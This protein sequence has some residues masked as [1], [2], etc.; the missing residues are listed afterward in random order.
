V[1]AVC[2]VVVGSGSARADE[3]APVI[4]PAA[5]AAPAPAAVDATAGTAAIVD[6]ASAPTPPTVISPGERARLEREK[7]RAATPHVG[8]QPHDRAGAGWL[9]AATSVGGLVAGAA[10]GLAVFVP[11][12]SQPAI[13][14]PLVALSVLAF[15]AGGAALGVQIVDDGHNLALISGV[16][17]GGALLGTALGVVGGGFAGAALGRTAGGEFSDLVGA[18][19]GLVIGGVVGGVTGAALGGGLGEAALGSE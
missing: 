1:L 14:L 19:G 10:V 4:G 15:T 9:V 13:A 12:S 17:A 18:L 8:P 5:T 2:A 7:Q 3:P 16:A 11:L 6:P